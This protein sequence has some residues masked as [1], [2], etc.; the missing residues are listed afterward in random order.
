MSSDAF[1]LQGKVALVTGGS[2]GIGR[3]T[4]LEFARHGADVAVVARKLPELEAVAQEIRALGRRALAVSAHVG[5]LNEITGLVSRVQQEF[6]QIDILVN[7]AGID[8]SRAQC[9]EV[10]ERLWDSVMNLNLKGLF[11]LGQ[12]VAK[13]MIERKSGSIINVGS[14]RGTRPGD[15]VYSISKAAVEMASKVMALELARYNV[16]VNT[17]APGTV[18]TRFTQIVWD[19]P[20][21]LEETV[22][23]IPLGFCA[24][25]GDITGAMLYLASDASRFVTGALFSIDGGE[26]I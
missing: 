1:S 19:T 20:G 7:N 18:Q 17:I 10:D 24:Q 14:L 12:A 8:P 5:R 4:A 3:A 9:L 23:R 6:G 2:H 25:P 22:G 11:F 13:L 16:R 26:S 15:P 21:M